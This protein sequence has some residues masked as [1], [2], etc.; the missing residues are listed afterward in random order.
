MMTPFA[1]L[2]PNRH[3]WQATPVAKGGTDAGLTRKRAADAGPRNGQHLDPQ[4]RVM[5]EPARGARGDA[6]A[7]GAVRIR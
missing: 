6:E 1:G 4:R 5:R 7:G 2:P 3:S